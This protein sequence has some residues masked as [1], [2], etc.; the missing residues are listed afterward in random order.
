[1]I[2]YI[3]SSAAAKL[4]F[5]EEESAALK[6]RL[7]E[8]AGDDAVSIVSCTLLETELRR[9]AGRVGSPQELVTDVL[10]RI[11][12]FDIDR[13]VF[14]AAGLLPG[15]IRSLDALHVAAALRIGAHVMVSYDERQLDA[16]RAAGLHTLSPA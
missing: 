3:E 12:I 14:R 16:A 6:K 10:D 11:E 13:T 1:M 4:M 5:D 15:V 8:L 7:D 2:L 9:T